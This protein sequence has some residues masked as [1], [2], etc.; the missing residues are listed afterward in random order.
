MRLCG[1]GQ[2]GGSGNS[3]LG[4]RRQPLNHCR[5]TMRLVPDEPGVARGTRVLDRVAPRVHGQS[6]R[7]YPNPSWRRGLKD[8]VV[9]TDTLQ[10]DRPEEETQL[11][12]CHLITD[13]EEI[14]RQDEGRVGDDVVHRVRR[15]DGQEV[16]A[17][18]AI[19][20]VVEIRG[21]DI[22]A[23]RL[24]DLGY[25]AVT[26]G[27]FPDGPLKRLVIQ[28]ECNRPRRGRVEVG[29]ALYQAS[30]RGHRA[31]SPLAQHLC[32]LV[33]LLWTQLGQQ[34]EDL[35]IGGE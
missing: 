17:A 14:L 31:S 26:T 33:P 3:R 10:E 28:E 16:L 6:F 24:Q 20:V 1:K 12:P 23:T 21:G 34:P 29:A 35:L 13:T 4:S 11:A 9:A 25:G 8:R 22:G 30:L 7:E 5:P 15:G 19:A 32:Q 2:G 27:R 18:D